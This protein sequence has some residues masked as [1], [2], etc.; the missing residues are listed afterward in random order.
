M[1]AGGRLRGVLRRPD[2]PLTD[3][4]ITLRAHEQGDVDA[5]VAI[6]QDPAIPRWTR[7]PEPY[8]RAD[9]LGWVAAVELEV[10][11]GTAMNWLA[12]DEHDDVVASIAVQDIRQ[13]EGIAEIGYWVAAAARGRGIATRAV[14]LATDWA[15]GELGLR[16]LEIMTHEDNTASQGV[17]RAAGY[18]ETGELT[19]SPREGLPPGRYLVFTAP[20]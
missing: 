9:A 8:T 4:V 7:V 1:V 12:V 3:G 5:L 17:A 18:V 6:C 11:T 13:D 19:V 15:L 10:T 14:R 16:R 20:A 2:P